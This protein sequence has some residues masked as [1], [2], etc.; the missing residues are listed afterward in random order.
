MLTFGGNMVEG[1]FFIK[2]PRATQK[3]QCQFRNLLRLILQLKNITGKHRNSLGGEFCEL[4]SRR[5][6]WK[7]EGHMASRLQNPPPQTLKILG[8]KRACHLTDTKPMLH[9]VPE[10]QDCRKMGLGDAEN[11]IR[12]KLPVDLVTG[13][14]LPLYA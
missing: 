13:P 1:L 4:H 9:Q 10:T 14:A 7:P 12:K 8:P 2:I 6:R 11:K 3:H 5:Q